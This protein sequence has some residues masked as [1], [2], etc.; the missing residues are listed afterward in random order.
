MQKNRLSQL[1]QPID[2][3]LYRQ[4]LN[5]YLPIFLDTCGLSR[6]NTTIRSPVNDNSFHS[7]PNCLASSPDSGIRQ[8]SLHTP[9]SFQSEAPVITSQPTTPSPLPRT[10]SIYPT[11][12]PATSTGTNPRSRNAGTSRNFHREW[13]GKPTCLSIKHKKLNKLAKSF[14]TNPMLFNAFV[15]FITLT[16]PSGVS[17]QLRHLFFCTITT[18]SVFHFS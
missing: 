3:F 6:M 4:H 9:L 12:L 18:S 1:N 16:T 5:D 11:N 17:V 15:S 10:S 13:Y 7:T 14:R 2:S 8:S